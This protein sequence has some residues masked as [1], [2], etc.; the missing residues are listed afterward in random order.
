MLLP[1]AAFLLA[2]AVPGI[3]HRRRPENEATA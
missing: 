2:A 3:A 1:F